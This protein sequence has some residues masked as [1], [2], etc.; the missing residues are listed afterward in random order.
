MVETKA[1]GRPESSFSSTMEEIRADFARL[2]SHF[3]PLRDCKPFSPQAYNAISAIVLESLYTC[4]QE[5]D[6]LTGEIP[7][8][9]NLALILYNDFHVAACQH[10][11]Q[12][13]ERLCGFVDSR[14]AP[15][16]VVR[17]R[18]NLFL[19]VSR[20]RAQESR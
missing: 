15:G 12:E 9:A 10:Y 2:T 17:V 8:H 16:R 13:Y 11:F 5:I 4:I 3:R 6:A 7:Y 18:G 1:M 14:L 20:V 19:A